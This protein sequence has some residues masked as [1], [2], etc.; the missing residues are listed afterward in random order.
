[1]ETGG[2]ELKVQICGGR[3]R[4]GGGTVWWVQILYIVG[5][6]WNMAVEVVQKMTVGR[7]VLGKIEPNRLWQ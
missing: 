4:W 6:L 5:R 1:M 3:S 7:I 2:M